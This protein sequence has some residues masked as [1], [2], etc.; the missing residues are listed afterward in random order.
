MTD[1]ILTQALLQS[2]FTYN[3]ITGIVIRKITVNPNAK[4]GD[5]VGTIDNG[6]LRVAISNKTYQLHRIIWF[7]KYGYFPKTIDHKNR[8]R[9]DN[10]FCNLREA[11]YIENNKN[12]G[13]CKNNTS[14]FNG[15]SFDKERNAWE[16]FIGYNGKKKTL[17]RFPTK[18]LAIQARKKAN[19]AFDYHPNHGITL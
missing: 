6:Y 18:N 9:S 19:I 12:I 3:P 10:R 16:A 14:G 2:L 13:I 8:N 15:V 17:G 7:M 4:A 5:I 1:Q 11:T